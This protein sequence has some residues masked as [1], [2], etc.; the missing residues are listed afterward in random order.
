MDMQMPRMDGLAATR[1][2]RAR[3]GGG[4][5]TPVVALTANVLAGQFQSCIEAGMDDVLTKPLEVAR[6]QD[7]LERFIAPLPEAPSASVRQA[8]PE[9][10]SAPLDLARLANLA[11][12]DTAFMSELVGVFRTSAALL[13]TEL[14]RALAAGPDRTQLLREAHRLKGA[15]ANVG[16]MGLGELAVRLESLAPA[17]DREELERCVEAIAAE[18]AELDRFFS[19]ADFATIVPRYA[20]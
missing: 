15:S 12:T 14:R 3:E 18:L 10:G 17:A 13:L 11:G 1:A 19:R 8:G 7:V 2:I 6:L 16:A 20:S 5:R 4:R 9:L